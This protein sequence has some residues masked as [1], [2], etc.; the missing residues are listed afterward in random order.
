MDPNEYLHM[1]T[2]E[3]DHWWYTGMRSIV[4]ALLP[5]DSL[6]RQARVLDAGCGTG[7]SMG[8]LRRR[9]GA[10]V[11]GIDYYPHGLVFCR[12]R[13][14][15]EL[16]RADAAELPF[17]DGVFDLV[18]SFD[19]LSHLR[20]EDSRSRAL[21]EFRR[22]LRPGGR[23]MARVAA[24][25]WLRSSHDNVI[26]THHRFGRCELRD[27][28][29]SAGF[30]LLRL[31]FANALLFPFAVLWRLAKRSGL[32]PGGSDVRPATRGGK[33]MNRMLQSILEAEAAVMRHSRIRFPFGLSL[34]VIAAKPRQ[35]DAA[36]G[37]AFAAESAAGR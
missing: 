33:R 32:A 36:A 4:A 12:Q 22:V 5:P 14:E 16:V 20:N 30:Q 11:T 26:M 15:R 37:Q 2:Q 25:E 27:A 17:T 8:W 24:H 10:R 7:Y 9:Y 34:I 31:T 19:V 13:G 21:C 1:Y 23:L 29:L 18:T 35:E 28:V 6:A 3:D